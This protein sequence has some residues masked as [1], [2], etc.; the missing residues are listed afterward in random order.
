MM[1]IR[2]M[3]IDDLTELRDLHSKFFSKDFPFPDFLNN[4]L[5]SFVVTDDDK[6]IT[7]GGVRLIAE[8]VIVTDKEYDINKR[9]KALIEMLRAS[10]FIC[11][12]KDFDQLHAFVT[13]EKWKRHLLKQGFKVA[14]G[15]TLV[16]GV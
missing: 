6:I 8:A 10:M 2:P 5:S 15:Q 14:K 1:N 7:G 9:R 11:G 3:E 13:D 12:I 4:Y 16:I